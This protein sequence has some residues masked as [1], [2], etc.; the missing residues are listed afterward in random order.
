MASPTRGTAILAKLQDEL[1]GQSSS[2]RKRE[3]RQELLSSDPKV[4]NGEE[5]VSEETTPSVEC[6]N[7]DE[8]K[9]GDSISI[10]CPK[11]T[12]GHFDKLSTSVSADK[13]AEF[14]TQAL[15][16]M[17]KNQM[18]VINKVLDKVTE[19][20]NHILYEP[21]GSQ[22]DGS[23]YRA[24]DSV[25]QQCLSEASEPIAGPSTAQR[26]SEQQAAG[27]SSPAHQ[28][29]MAAPSQPSKPVCDLGKIASVF[30][31]SDQ[32]GPRIETELADLVEGLLI[33]K[34][35]EKQK[36]EIFEKHARPENCP[37]LQPSRVNSE[38]WRIMESDSKSRDI[39]AQKV[40]NSIC[41]GLVPI[42]KVVD[43]LCNKETFDVSSLVTQLVDGIALI[44]SANL[45]L[46]LKRRDA[47]R[48]DIRPE[49][50]QLCAHTN[51]IT[52]YLFGD[53]L[54]E[55]IKE[56]TDT[57]KLVTKV[58]NVTSHHFHPYQRGG[59]SR[60][61]VFR[62]TRGGSQRGRGRFLGNGGP[63]FSHPYSRRP[64]RAGKRTKFL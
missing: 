30:K 58:H 11:G 51:P 7:I 17:E 4:N 62:G 29:N 44:A 56:L 55:Q 13:G 6:N 24:D 33:T 36:A 37:K 23:I 15:H 39:R 18:A 60:P 47:I 40:Q 1:L 9:S 38:I 21:E 22:C 50:K 31:V 64:Q 20:E 53:N 28:N 48:G 61:P 46:S 5:I 63:R 14:F 10:G 59:Q 43:T 27:V 26:P 19:L 34:L 42:V 8:E 12:S 52:E 3:S 25:S 57:N 32:T 41:K 45:D 2:A 35:D 49:F 54:S 16:M